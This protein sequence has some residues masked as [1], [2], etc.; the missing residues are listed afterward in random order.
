MTYKV[1]WPVHFKWQRCVM[2]G[3]KRWQKYFI[4][5]QKEK[6]TVKMFLYYIIFKIE[7]RFIQGI[8]RGNEGEGIHKALGYQFGQ[9]QFFFFRNIDSV[10]R[11]SGMETTHHPC[12]CPETIC[13]TRLLDFKRHCPGPRTFLRKKSLKIICSPWR[14]ISTVNKESS[15]LARLLKQMLNNIMFQSGMCWSP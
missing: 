2:F 8:R 12:R 10:L 11:K 9:Y 14:K 7:C 4:G 3:W 6:Y 15:W 13:L 5:N 1:K